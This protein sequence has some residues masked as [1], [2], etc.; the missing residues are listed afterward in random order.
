M[1]GVWP[2]LLL[3]VAGILTGGAYSVHKQGGSKVAV[4]LLGGVALVSGL[5]GFFWFLPES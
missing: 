5:G 1:G 4:S 2:I 3:A